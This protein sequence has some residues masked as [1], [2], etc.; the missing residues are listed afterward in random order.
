MSE[1]S[2]VAII[3][4]D[5]TCPEGARLQVSGETGTT[6]LACKEP[7]GLDHGALESD[8]VRGLVQWS[9]PGAFWIL[10]LG[11]VFVGFIG[12]LLLVQRGVSK[13]GKRRGQI[14]DKWQEFAQAAYNT[15]VISERD[16]AVQPR[17]R[18]FHVTGGE[19]KTLKQ[20]LTPAD[21][22]D[23]ANTVLRKKKRSWHDLGK[24]LQRHVWAID[25]RRRRDA[26]HLWGAGEQARRNQWQLGNGQIVRC[27]LHR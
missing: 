16:D 20:Q 12:L 15:V 23:T 22:N 4:T 3:N 7:Y 25:K 1:E 5:N 10:I 11:T 26:D 24:L 19:L 21:Y 9:E 14:Q 27:L 18:L 2:S 6:F 8:E 17:Q 13:R